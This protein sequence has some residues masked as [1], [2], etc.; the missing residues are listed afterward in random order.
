MIR[1][2]CQYTPNHAKYVDERGVY[3][4]VMHSLATVRYSDSKAL[5]NDL[6]SY[7]MTEIHNN[8]FVNKDNHAFE[9]LSHLIQKAIKK[10]IIKYYVIQKDGFL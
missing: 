8:A 6:I 3:D 4:D 1:W 5:L 2:F 10:I 7:Q 9:T